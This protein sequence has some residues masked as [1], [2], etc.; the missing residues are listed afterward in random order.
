MACRRELKNLIDAIK[1]YGRWYATVEMAFHECN[2]HGNSERCEEAARLVDAVHR[3]DEDLEEK[4]A[5]LSECL[6]REKG[7]S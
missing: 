2:V 3:L 7:G 6:R 4:I 5:K 1:E